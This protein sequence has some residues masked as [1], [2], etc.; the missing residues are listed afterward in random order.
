MRIVIFLI[1][2]SKFV[3]PSEIY[4]VKSEKDNERKNYAIERLIDVLN[5]KNY[6]VFILK[7][8]TLAENE[9]I[10][11]KSKNFKKFLKP[12][13]SYNLKSEGYI[14]R[15]DKNFI[16]IFG[17]DPSG[18]L[19][20]CIE[21]INRFI[22][23]EI[24]FDRYYIN[25]NPEMKIRGACIGLQKT[26]YLPRHK[27]YEYPIT[28]QNFPWF[29]DTILW[30]KYL[31][32]LVNNKMNALYL[33]NGH[34]F[35][36]LVRLEDYP[37]AIE[38]DEKTFE[39]NK[40]IY[41]FLT[42]EANRR[43]IWV[44]QMFYN[45]IV[46][47]PFANYHGIETQNRN[48]PITP[49]LSDYTRKSIATF[50]KEYPNVGLMVCLGEAMNTIDDDIEWFTKTI[51]PGV[52]DGLEALGIKEEPPIILRAHDTDA[53]K[54]INAALPLYNNLYTMHKYNGEALTTYQPRGAWAELHQKLSKLGSVHI[55]NVHILAN[56]E[57]FRYGSPN[58]I[59]KCVVAMHDILGANGLHLY[60]QASYWD[61]PY[62]ADNTNPRLLEM[63]RDWIWYKAWSR[64]AWNCRRDEKEE[65]LYW[66]KVFENYYGL[67]KDNGKYL[68]IA[69]NEMGEIA[70]KLLRRFGITDG[71]RQTLTLGMFMSQLVNPYKWQVYS[72]FYSS[73]GPEGEILIE[74]ARKEWYKE[75]HIG[76]TPV[77]IINEVIEH[78]KKAL[79][80]IENITP[81]ITCNKDEF[82][83]LKNDIYCY[84]YL[85]YFFY[86]K[87]KSALK[88]LNYKYSKNIVDLDSAIFYLENSV[89]YYQK[90]ADITKKTYLYANSMQTQQRRIPI[91][92]GDSKNKHWTELLLH[93]QKELENFKH[94]V[95]LIKSYGNV[96]LT[97]NLKPFKPVDVKIECDNCELYE[98]KKKQKVFIDKDY[99]I[100]DIA[101][102]L[103]E[104][105]GIRFSYDNQIE[106]GSEFTFYAEKPV[107]L[108]LGYF[109]GN[110]L[111]LLKPPTLETDA[112]AAEYGQADIKIAN[113][114]DIPNL[115][116]VNVYNI[117]F[118][119]GQHIVKLNKG[120]VLI[121]GFID[122]SIELPIRDAGLGL[123]DENA[124]ID[125]L[126]Y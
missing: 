5:K 54:V 91:S 38:V 70:P 106:N 117:T 43:G 86:E 104:L 37:Y 40:K 74:Y 21:V 6:K 81:F 4:L 113:A 16:H 8:S 67:Q 7:S 41:N 15:S 109:N 76:E 18:I 123:T 87:V 19:Y 33:W 103:G 22:D 64:Y 94:N 105:K 24:L 125:W 77:H 107:K 90:L 36:S 115:Y 27:V 12:V 100:N 114:I 79:N 72:N 48:R 110:S 58:F 52:R 20:G 119:A 97:E 55:A 108:L 3:F 75:S 42:R 68:L 2:I 32:L 102:E 30:K 111:R 13:D 112:N 44:I 17:N 46:S 1:F 29:Y 31:D 25:E 53:E 88:V 14:I 84:Y 124:S 73:N 99:F 11:L 59:R 89:D 93:Y 50:I 62:T 85:S 57:P 51:I 120:L 61:W 69:Y 66:S 121:I 56:L 65:N 98:L 60:P 92:G 96:N 118:N 126:F 71:N 116:P 101:I 122:G 26:T 9:I 28:P 78:A 47:K 39:L 34:P 63:D 45:I 23:Q 35:A 80:A 95:D 83:R 49:L 10:L 82:L